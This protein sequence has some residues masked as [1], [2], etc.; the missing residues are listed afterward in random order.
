MRKGDLSK[1]GKTKYWDF[2]RH[3]ILSS[4]H[5]RGISYTPAAPTNY[6]TLT[7]ESAFRMG[8]TLWQLAAF[9]SPLQ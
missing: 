6:C 2:C 5:F 9:I 1:K 7:F 8:E 3:L 4:V